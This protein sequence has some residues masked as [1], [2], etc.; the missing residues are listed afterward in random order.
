MGGLQPPTDREIRAF[1][2]ASQF[3]TEKNELM[4]ICMIIL[5]HEPDMS[6]DDP[7]I[8]ADLSSFQP[9]T[10]W[11]LIYFARDRLRAKGRRYPGF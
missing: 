11:A 2:S 8:E 10:I 4:E 7:I 1:M 9:D 6:P 5:R 3:L